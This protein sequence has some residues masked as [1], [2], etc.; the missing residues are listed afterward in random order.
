[1]RASE[2]VLAFGIGQ[3]LLRLLNMVG[4][5][6]SAM[7]IYKHLPQ[8]LG[9]VAHPAFPG[10]LIV[11]GFLLLWKFA[12][13]SEAVGPSQIVHPYTKQPFVPPIYP[14]F[15]RAGWACAV[16]LCLAIPVWAWYKTPLRSYAF[17]EKQVPSSA[18]LHIPGPPDLVNKSGRHDK[19]RSPNH[20]SL[21]L[22]AT[23]PSPGTPTQKADVKTPDKAP[24]PPPIV[25]PIPDRQTIPRP[26]EN[27]AQ[28]IATIGG[29][30]LRASDKTSGTLYVSVRIGEPSTYRGLVDEK[31]TEAVK[32]GLE[33]TGKITAFLGGYDVG[34]SPG[35][36]RYGIGGLG[37]GKSG[38]VYYFDKKLDGACAAIQKIVSD[39][40]GRPMVCTFV[41]PPAAPNDPN[42]ISFQRDFWLA[43]GLDMEIVL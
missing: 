36:R 16:A 38:S 41:E 10:F 33:K 6:E 18:R 40:V 4:K 27:I 34:T 28:P 11:S 5:G 20:G 15:R 21:P 29:K 26:P 1:V 2:T 24:P 9:V 22:P 31:G 42:E 19:P 12:K 35:S 14:A 8:V 32:A 43:S 39:I 17:V 7:D 25:I 37:F 23:N 13:Q 30:S 3:Y